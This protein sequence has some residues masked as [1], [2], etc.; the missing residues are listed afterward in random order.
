MTQDEHDKQTLELL[1]T[2]QEVKTDENMQNLRQHIETPVQEDDPFQARVRQALAM[3]DN[4]DGNPTDRDQ[5]ALA[6][7]KA[8][9]VAI[10]EAE[11]NRP[12]TVIA[13]SSITTAAWPQPLLRIH[14]QQGAV[15]SAG[16]TCTL[17]G[18][19]GIAKSTLAAAIALEMA[20]NTT[21]AMTPMG[22]EEQNGFIEGGI[23]DVSGGPVLLVLYEDP[24]SV[25][26][27]KLRQLAQRLD[28]QRQSANYQEALERVLLLDM[29]GRPLYGPVDRNGPAGSYNARPGPLPGWTDL[30]TAVHQ[31]K[32]KLIVID[33]ALKAYTGEPNAPVAVHQFLAHLAAAARLAVSTPGVLIL[34]HSNKSSRQDPDPTNPGKVAGAA[35]WTDG[36]RGTMTMT[37][38]AETDARR[39]AVVKANFGPDRRAIRLEKITAA[40]TTMIIGFTAGG[41]QW[42]D[43]GQRTTTSNRNGTTAR[44]RSRKT[45]QRS[46][47]KTY[48]DTGAN[49]DHNTPDPHAKIFGRGS[50][51]G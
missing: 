20:A 40:D 33:P 41:N 11:M 19:G 29:G 30:W 15:L 22:W 17:A 39:L 31:E 43:I 14:G 46:D 2:Y 21:D 35:A 9:P 51:T 25:V 27:W 32:P 6:I 16:E 49:G 36:G 24:L 3:L 37:R 13:A 7:L 8:D 44:T 42:A 12:R 34:H 23:L 50:P 45:T 4:S 47:A 48:T 26:G 1:K 10:L 38:D 18:D 28:Q 5:Q